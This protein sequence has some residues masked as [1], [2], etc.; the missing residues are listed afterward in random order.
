MVLK[1]YD[2][3]RI[4]VR[5]NKKLDL[6]KFKAAK[7]DNERKKAFKDALKKDEFGKNI[8]KMQRV[9]FNRVFDFGTA[10]QS[11][12]DGTEIK[13]SIKRFTPERQKKITA[14]KGELRILKTQER[15]FRGAERKGIKVRG[16]KVRPTKRILRK[17]KFIDV[18]IGRKPTRKIKLDD[19]TFSKPFKFGNRTVIGIYKKGRRGAIRLEEVG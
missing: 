9:N 17:G 19:V 11:I 14:F 18:P 13:E 8:L 7:T 16:I 12:D 5:L 4:W 2:Q 15:L 6:K 1:D 10:Q 3:E